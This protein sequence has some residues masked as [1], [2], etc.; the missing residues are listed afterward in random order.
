MNGSMY[1]N[2]I[3]TSTY[4]PQLSTISKSS[5]LLTIP[6]SSWSDFLKIPKKYLSSSSSCILIKCYNTALSNRSWGTFM[7]VEY[8][9]L[10]L[11]MIRSIVSRWYRQFSI[12]YSASLNE[13][14][15][16]G[17]EFEVILNFLIWAVKT[18]FNFFRWRWKLYSISFLKT[19]P[20]TAI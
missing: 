2:S 16:Y 17:E 13:I 18:D 5:F 6:S 7:V 8:Y 4:F 10:S 9:Y 20:N 14:P 11:G 1:S 3:W 12:I 19:L 15:S